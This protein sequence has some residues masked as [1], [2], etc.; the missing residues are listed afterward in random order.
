MLI[1]ILNILNVFIKATLIFKFLHRKI[2]SNQ[3]ELNFDKQSYKSS[4]RKLQ[5]NNG[6]IKI[7][8]KH[9]SKL[10]YR[11]TDCLQR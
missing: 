2:I 9:V 8:Q 11:Q 10:G 4:F 6:F 3:V 7:K 5:Y 1:K